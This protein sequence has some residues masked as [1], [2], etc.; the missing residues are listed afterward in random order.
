MGRT[1]LHNHLL[2]GVDDGAID[3]AESLALGRE[4]VAAGYTDVAVTPH[5][6]PDLDPDR[7]LV[8]ARRAEVQALFEREGIALRL[9]DGCENHLTPE[10]L[11]R[12]GGPDARTL[13]ESPY[14]L[15]ELPF[16]SPVPGLRELLFQIMLKGKRPLLAH[17]ERVAQFVGRLDAAQEAFDAGAHFQIEIGSLA[18]IYGAPAKRTA[19]AMLDGGLVTIAATDA[20]HPRTGHEILTAGM[21]ALGKAVGPTRLALLTEEN[22]AR[23]LRGTTLLTA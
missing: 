5:A 8:R 21:K 13:A 22:P 7:A 15:V 14:V 18:G 11:A 10:F 23:V 19:Q 1:D 3:A 9:H 16:A 4:L 12:V 2:W 20:H 6:K 17:P